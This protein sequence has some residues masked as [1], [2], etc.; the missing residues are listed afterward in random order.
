MSEGQQRRASRLAY[1]TVIYV[2]LPLRYGDFRWATGNRNK[3]ERKKKKIS[4][5]KKMK[6]KSKE[7]GR[8]YC[9]VEATTRRSDSW[10]VCYVQE[11]DRPVNRGSSH[12]HIHLSLSLSGE[13]YTPGVGLALAWVIISITTAVSPPTNA[14]RPSEFQY[15]RG[16][17]LL[18]KTPF[19]LWSFRPSVSLGRR[20]GRFLAPN[21]ASKTEMSAVHNV[22]VRPVWRLRDEGDGLDGAER[23]SIRP[24]V[25][26]PP[27]SLY[28]TK[29]LFL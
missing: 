4:C 10:Q 2:S 20:H 6:K 5:D 11:R 18:G 25:Q 14:P 3:F 26:Q 19:R 16:R 17:P 27:V 8:R 28:C 7:K 24:N 15:R 1:T 23:K 9:Q 29:D 12:S 21:S 13:F 22:E